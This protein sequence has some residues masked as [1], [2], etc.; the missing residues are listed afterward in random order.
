[1]KIV[2]YY[3]SKRYKILASGVY[4]GY[5]F[6]RSRLSMRR[7]MHSRTAGNHTD[8]ISLVKARR[9]YS[10]RN[11]SRPIGETWMGLYGK[12][13][14]AASKGESR[15][16]PNPPLVQASS[17]PC[18]AVMKKKYAIKSHHRFEKAFLF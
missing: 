18:E 1:M 15:A 13:Y 14:L 10:V 16:M 2:S 11:G 4:H 3:T 8:M 5:Y 9:P 12:K 7:K 17:K 6:L